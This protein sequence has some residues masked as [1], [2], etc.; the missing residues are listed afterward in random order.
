M[1]RRAAPRFASH[2]LPDNT[3]PLNFSSINLQLVHDLFHRVSRQ[4]DQSDCSIYAGCLGLTLATVLIRQLGIPL[5][6]FP[7]PARV[8]GSR[9]VTFLAGTAGYHTLRA[10]LTAG[11][12]GIE[13]LLGMRRQVE[14]LPREDCELLYGR[15]GYLYALLFLRKQLNRPDLARDLVPQ[16]IEQIVEEGR[17]RGGG[18]IL[19][20][21]WHDTSYLGAVHGLAGILYILL[22]C[23]A[24][25]ISP[26]SSLIQETAEWW[27][28]KC[29]LPSG[30]F[31][32][33]LESTSD[34]LVQFCHGATGSVP[35]L[36]ALS[37]AF[38]SRAAYYRQVALE[39]GEVI[40]ERGL[41]IAKGPGICHGIPGSICAFLDLFALCE[42]SKWLHR[43]QHFVLF[44]VEHLE[45]LLPLAD[46][47]FSLFEGASG[48][49]Y[50]IAATLQA[51]QLPKGGI[52]SCFP[53]LGHI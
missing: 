22:H 6:I 50:A 49:L 45:E 37:Q 29:R 44:L 32:S 16:L 39:T 47:P 36:C 10:L 8:K 23:Q 13:D 40:W 21:Q 33:S 28:N 51:E 20:W 3:E 52:Q 2:S 11:Q 9:R 15:A 18:R 41:L 24:H 34:K 14:A 30:N 17:R 5:D 4:Q 1:S 43:A 35:L 31:R 7:L 12:N 26:Y 46:N 27:M 48:A 19:L 53:G 42:D 38:P 25:E